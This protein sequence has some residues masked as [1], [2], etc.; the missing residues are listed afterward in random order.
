MRTLHPLNRLTYN[1]TDGPWNGFTALEEFYNQYDAEDQRKDQFIV[2]QQFSSD[3]TPLSDPNGATEVD[4]DGDPDPDGAPLIF[5]PEINELTPKA[6]S[7]S[8]ARLGKFEFESGIS[9]SAQN[10]FPVLRYADVLLMRA[11]ALWRLDNGNAESVELVRQIRE[12]SGLEKIDPL[13]ETALYD[14][15]LRELAYEAHARPTMIRFGT[16]TAPRWEK[17]LSD[18]TKEIFPIPE[19]Q[20]NGNPNLG[21]NPGY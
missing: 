2:G 14:E 7:Q 3:G 1:L 13:T 5:T 8:G 15:I 11:E 20:R 21:Q 6:F 19:P 18:E 16:F 10:D 9:L 17:N 4:S 12:R